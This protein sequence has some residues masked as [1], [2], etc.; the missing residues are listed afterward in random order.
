MLHTMHFIG[1]GRSHD[2]ALHMAGT[3][4]NRTFSAIM[5][6]NGQRISQLSTILLPDP[7]PF[8]RQVALVYVLDVPPGADE[9]LDARRAEVEQEVRAAF[10]APVFD[11]VCFPFRAAI[12]LSP[13]HRATRQLGP[14]TIIVQPDAAAYHV[15]VQLCNEE[16]HVSE[17]CANLNEC[18]G[19][20]QGK[21]IPLNGWCA[22]EAAERK[23]G[24]DT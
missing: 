22:S 2:E 23:H 24:V 13:N 3:I 16:P 8:S 18:E 11:Q 1:R 15:L 6:L 21:G 10:P 17:L 7:A 14:Y 4:A 9:I 12:G 19:F 20:L 5:L